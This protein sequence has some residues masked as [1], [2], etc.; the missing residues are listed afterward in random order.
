V[1]EYILNCLPI[2]VKTVA[3]SYKV[4]GFSVHRMRK[5]MAHNNRRQ[6][7][8]SGILYVFFNFVFLYQLL[9]LLLT[10]KKYTVSIETG[11]PFEGCV[12]WIKSFAY[13]M[14]QMSCDSTNV[15]ISWTKHYA[16]ICHLHVLDIG[17][18]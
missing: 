2:A 3:I 16:D 15:K 12:E 5:T 1:P 7:L 11:Q 18:V 9:M 6:K 10:A 17:Y 14:Q 4:I 13:V 8:S